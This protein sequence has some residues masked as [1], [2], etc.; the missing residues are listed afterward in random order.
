MSGC[1]IGLAPWDALAGEAARHLAGREEPRSGR[2][3]ADVTEQRGRCR[4]QRGETA[5]TGQTVR[6]L[7][8]DRAGLLL[9]PPAI[10]QDE[11]RQTEPDTDRRQDHAHHSQC[12][13]IASSPKG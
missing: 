2:P 3:E 4:C 5:R 10:D 7:S 1:S 9:A 13:H 12:L 8:N 11:A 6:G